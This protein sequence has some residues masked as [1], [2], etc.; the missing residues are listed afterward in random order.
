MDAGEESP[1]VADVNAAG[2]LP[3][4][5]RIGTDDRCHGLLFLASYRKPIPDSVSG[6]HG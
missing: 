5:S 1:V 2:F 4:D 6:Q 3:I